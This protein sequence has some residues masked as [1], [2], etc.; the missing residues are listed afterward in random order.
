MENSYRFI[1]SINSDMLKDFYGFIATNPDVENL[2]IYINSIGGDVS[3]SIGIYNLIKNLRFN[4]T[5]HNLGDV[6]SAA[7]LIYLAGKKR[8]AEDISKFMIHPIALTI[9]KTILRFQAE[10]IL[11]S[12]SMDIENYAAIVNK[13]TEN[14]KGVYDIN[15]HLNYESLHLNKEKALACGIVTE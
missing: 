2:T 15:Y 5:T 6:S 13:E 9:N 3:A 10:E 14:L 7:L 11:N 8:T 12:I 1:G 4:V